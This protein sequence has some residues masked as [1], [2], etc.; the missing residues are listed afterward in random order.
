MLKRFLIFQ[1][2]KKITVDFPYFYTGTP[3]QPMSKEQR[4]MASV[5][6]KMKQFFILTSLC[7]VISV[8]LHLMSAANVT[9]CVRER[10]EI[11]DL[12]PPKVDQKDI[13]Q[14]IQGDTTNI[15]AMYWKENE[16]AIKSLENKTC[17]PL[18][19][20]TK[21][22]FSNTYWQLLSTSNG[23]FHLFSAY[24]DSR[25]L[26]DNGP[27]VRI[28]AMIDVPVYT[29]CQ[30]RF[31]GQTHPE[32][33][34]VDSYKLMYFKVPV[35]KGVLLPYLINCK[36]PSEHQD[37]PETVS[38][39]ENLCDKATNMLKVVNNVPSSGERKDFAVC[40]K[41]LDFPDRDMS[42]RLVEWM[43][44]LTQLGVHKVFFYT[45]SVHPNTEKVLDYYV[46]KDK[47][48][49]T[50]LTLP[51]NLPNLPHLRNYYQ[52]VEMGS[53][54]KN[55]VLPYND[56]FYKNLY[57]YKYIAVLDIDEV[58]IPK[59]AKTWRELLDENPKG[60]THDGYQFRNAYFL[61]V[62]NRENEAL[63]DIPNY[64]HMLRNVYRTK[65]TKPG[66]FVKSF[67]DPERVLTVFNHYPLAC[68]KGPCSVYP[69]STDVA[70]MQHYRVDCVKELHNYCYELRNASTMDTTLWKYKEKLIQQVHMVLEDLDW[71][72]TLNN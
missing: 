25:K 50:P 16:A 48:S 24:Y 29:T 3:F 65:Y 53:K 15:P 20:I 58:I 69:V 56:C 7:F 34:K 22:S 33:S 37:V 42:T 43:E 70:Q 49:V 21:L 23:T 10:E 66:Y 32:F 38:L 47:A 6:C 27:V 1:V 36:V 46:E 63:Y 54:R 62:L 40:V 44:L 64:M 68:L 2:L 12:K 8:S 45:F 71:I 19:D 28:V 9:H 60:K 67:N 55:E 11:H 26:V 59:K 5:L 57:S 4:T 72:R 30:F 41:A 61:E 17:A 13:F 39:V 31:Q 52:A 35:K 18:P 14:R 51:G